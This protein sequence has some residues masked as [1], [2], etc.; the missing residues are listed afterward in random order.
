MSRRLL[1]YFLSDLTA[2]RVVCQNRF[3]EATTEV[4]IDKLDK[5]KPA[6]PVCGSSFG[7]DNPVA[8][9]GRALVALQAIEGMVRVELVATD[10]V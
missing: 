4:S 3:C 2:A 6:C 10:A 7:D 5:L 1:A 9:L 8:A